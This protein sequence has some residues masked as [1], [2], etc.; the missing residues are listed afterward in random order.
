[1]IEAHRVGGSNPSLG[2]CSVSSSTDLTMALTIESVASNQLS[3]SDH[4]VSGSTADCHS[5]SRSSNLLDRSGTSVPK[6]RGNT[7]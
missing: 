5:A 6:G 2:T 1:M 7:G 3:T 4:G